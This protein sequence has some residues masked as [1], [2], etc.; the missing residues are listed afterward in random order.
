MDFRDRVLPKSV[1]PG[2][3]ACILWLPSIPR[4]RCSQSDPALRLVLGVAMTV[5]SGIFGPVH[6]GILSGIQL[7]GAL[8]FQRRLESCSTTSAAG[9]N[10]CVPPPCGTTAPPKSGAPPPAGSSAL[11]LTYSRF[12]PVR[13]RP[14]ATVCGFPFIANYATYA[15]SPATSSR[16]AGWV[17]PV[18]T[19]VSFGVVQG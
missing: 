14:P 10:R 13:A 6:T 7:Y 9:P 19:S 4:F 12:R 3:S 18:A 1:F 5:H 17:S 11:P 15:T 16:A 8:R 2:T